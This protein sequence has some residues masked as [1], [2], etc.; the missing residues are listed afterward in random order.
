MVIAV[1]ILILLFLVQQFGTG[2]VGG[3]FSPVI[4]VWLFFNTG[5]GLY[6]IIVYRPDIFK[7]FGPNYWF[8]F[9]LRNG[10]GGWEKLGGV[11]LCVTGGAPS[12]NT[13]Q[14]LCVSQCPYPGAIDPAAGQHGGCAVCLN[15]CLV[16]WRACTADVPTAGSWVL[17]VLLAR[18]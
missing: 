13:C 12:S 17:H 8:A 16:L 11:V 15:C 4:L 7:A 5:I 2:V 3:I 18:H 14:L 10:R 1:V 6:N 9:F